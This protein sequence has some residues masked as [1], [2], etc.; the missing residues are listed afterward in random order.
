MI[1][2]LVM[3]LA[4]EA[5]VMMNLEIGIT[6]M[7]LK[8]QVTLMFL[9]PVAMMTVPVFEVMMMV[10]KLVTVKLSRMVAATMTTPV[11]VITVMDLR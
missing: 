4:Y 6:T 3:I 2:A 8:R 9:E 1:P 7:V 10:L 11:N 5:N